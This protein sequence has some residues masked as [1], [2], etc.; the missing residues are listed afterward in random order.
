MLGLV[1]LFGLGLLFGL[2]NRFY[3]G[4]SWWG[5]GLWGVGLRGLSLRFRASTLGFRAQVLGPRIYG[6]GKMFI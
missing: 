4:G 3:I 2:L 6:S 5:V 1:W